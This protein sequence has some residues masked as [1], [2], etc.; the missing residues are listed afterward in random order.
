MRAWD[1]V[2][3]SSTSTLQFV[4]RTCCQHVSSLEVEADVSSVYKQPE[5]AKLWEGEPTW[6][7]AGSHTGT[8]PSV[9]RL[10]PL[11]RY[12]P[13]CAVFVFASA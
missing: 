3:H 10:V 2:G 5:W 7:A 12:W 13:G 8:C 9:F 6:L 1:M 11:V 4:E